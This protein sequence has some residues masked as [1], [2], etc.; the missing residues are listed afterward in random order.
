MRLRGVG[1]ILCALAIP[2]Y[3]AIATTA[4]ARDGSRTV[5]DHT[6]GHSHAGKD[7]SVYQGLKEELNHLYESIDPANPD[8]T[9]T[10]ADQYQGEVSNAVDEGQIS[11][12]QANRLNRSYDRAVGSGA[13]GSSDIGG[14]P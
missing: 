6:T 8:E 7:R 12:G 10:Y 3:G 5:S 1:L 11:K 9:R 2:A 4:V 14:I 13:L